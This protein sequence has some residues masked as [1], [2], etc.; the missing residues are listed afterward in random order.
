M[1]NLKPKLKILVIVVLVL[2]LAR[3]FAYIP[4]ATSIDFGTLR[5]NLSSLGIR[6][7]FLEPEPASLSVE[8]SK[9]EIERIAERDKHVN[10]TRAKQYIESATTDYYQGSYEEALRRLDRAR[11]Y[12]PSNFSIFKLSGQIFFEKSKYRKAFNDWERANQLPNDDRTITRD[13]DVLKRLIRYSRTE[14]DRL[15]RTLN[16]QPDDR[17]ARARLKE[18]EEQMRE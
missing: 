14:I 11:I 6:T 15:N 8:I 9:V 7:D 18:L 4:S 3:Y 16:V 5:Q 13:I 17:V 1:K 10:E 2:A 12:D